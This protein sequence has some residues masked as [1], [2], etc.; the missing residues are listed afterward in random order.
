VRLLIYDATQVSRPPRGLGLSWVVGARLYRTLGWLDASFGARS[1]AEALDWLARVKP[2]RELGEVQFWGHGK[3]GRALI[4]RE[5]FDRSCLAPAHALRKP[6]EGLRERLTSDA[7]VWF[8]T[9]E[10]L[11]AHAGQDF[12]RA[13][14]DFMGAR[15]AGHTYEIGYWQSGLHALAPGAAPDWDASEG[16]ARG[17]A[18]A[19]ERALT[20][21]PDCPNTITCFTP[22]LPTALGQ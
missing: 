9:C 13:L 17:H 20:S 7:L 16:L 22:R 15:V 3:W 6:L 4:E 14:G 18:G 2:G 21:G 11:G 10:T 5:S 8:R 1:F 12:A 19:P